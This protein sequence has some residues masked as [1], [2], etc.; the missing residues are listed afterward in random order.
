MRNFQIDRDKA[1]CLAEE[2]GIKVSFNSQNPGVIINQDTKEL[3][4]FFPELNTITHKEFKV[5]R[6][7]GLAIIGDQIVIRQIKSKKIINNFDLFNHHDLS[8]AA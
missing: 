1:H 5:I 7:E 4:E 6:E 2:L 3:T 8:K